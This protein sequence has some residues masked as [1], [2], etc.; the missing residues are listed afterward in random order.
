MEGL[1]V[2]RQILLPKAAPTMEAERINQL[3]ALLSDL[4]RRVQDLRGYL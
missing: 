4:A 3:V 1:S 2:L